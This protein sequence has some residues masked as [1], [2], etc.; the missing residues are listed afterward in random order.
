MDDPTDTTR[1]TVNRVL[2]HERCVLRLMV[3]AGVA[4]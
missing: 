2:H 4:K 3:E 1:R